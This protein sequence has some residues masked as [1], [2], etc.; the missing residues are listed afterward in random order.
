MIK[1]SETLKSSRTSTVSKDGK[2]YFRLFISY[3][4]KRTFNDDSNDTILNKKIVL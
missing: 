3:K 4:K 2:V 1:Y